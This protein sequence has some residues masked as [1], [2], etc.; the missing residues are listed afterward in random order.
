MM[1]QIEPS[2]IAQNAQIVGYQ[3]YAIKNRDS[4]ILSRIDKEISLYL[5]GIKCQNHGS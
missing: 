2:S 5:C 3:H 1:H 4:D